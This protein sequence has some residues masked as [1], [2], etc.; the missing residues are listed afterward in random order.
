[1]SAFEHELREC[2]GVVL[3]SEP[4]APE[5]DA[6]V[7]FKQWLGETNLGLVPI[8]AAA[9]FSWPGEWLARV[10][11]ADGDHAV[12]MY[13]SPSGPIFD[14]AGAL[15]RGGT[16]EEG[17][18]VAPL[19]LHVPIE[20]PWGQQT[21]AGVVAAILVAPEREAPLHRV[22]SVEAIA[23]SGLAGDRYAKGIGTFNATGRGYELT[24]VEADALAD[25]DLSWEQARR[26]I[27]TKASG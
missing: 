25:V 23:G 18:L 19:D 2:L 20:Q 16:I 1:M 21:E 3:G 11:V 8:A 9:G 24:L 15:A 26:N 12:V 17:W 6:L 4:P 10:R 5:F 27:V 13:G 14:P 7:F 22:D